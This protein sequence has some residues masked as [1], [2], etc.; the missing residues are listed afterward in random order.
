MIAPIARLPRAAGLF[1]VRRE[2]C[3]TKMAPHAARPKI[4][5]ELPDQ[6]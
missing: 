1:F 2:I 6:S 4:R 5:R 3:A